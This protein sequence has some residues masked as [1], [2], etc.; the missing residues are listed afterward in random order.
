MV[1]YALLAN[2]YHGELPI[3]LF[4]KKPDNWIFISAKGGGGKKREGAR[5]GPAGPFL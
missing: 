4:S 1:N 3:L 2:A 5:S